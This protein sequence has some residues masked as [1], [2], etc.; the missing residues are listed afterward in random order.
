[1]DV[2]PGQRPPNVMRQ[3]LRET[4][5]ISI[6]E[7]PFGFLE[8]AIMEHWPK[9]KNYGHWGHSVIPREVWLQIVAT[10]VDLGNSMATEKSAE[11]VAERAFLFE[12]VKIEFTRRFENYKAKLVSMIKE[13]SGWVLHQLSTHT[14]L[15]II[16]I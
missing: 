16:G 7:G 11:H 10:W 6:Q 14:H 15:T 2:F 13:L 12:D 3:E 1:M 8:P 4:G 5:A 9:Y